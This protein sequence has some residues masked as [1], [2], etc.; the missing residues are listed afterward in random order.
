MTNGIMVYA[1]VDGER[2][3]I[4]MFDDLESLGNQVDIHLI[5]MGQGDLCPYVYFLMNGNEYKLFLERK[6][7]K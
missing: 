5:R 2:Q 3:F 4:G 1:K 7:G 6:D